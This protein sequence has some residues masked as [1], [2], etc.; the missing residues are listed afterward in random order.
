[1][2][3]LN[4]LR[5]FLAAARCGSFTRAARDLCITQPAVSGHIAQLEAA[6]GAEL[7]NRTGREVVLTDAGR[8]VQKAARDIMDRLESMQSELADLEALKGGTIKIGASKIIGV[9]LLPKIITAF[10]EKFPEIELQVA[11]HNAH[12]IA[13]SVLDNAF[14]I[15]IVA[16]GDQF[17]SKS[18]GSTTI[19]YDD[20]TIIASPEYVRR[21]FGRTELSVEQAGRESFILPGKATASAQNLKAQLAEL[22][23]RLRSTIEIDEAGA[24]KRAVED[25]A[26]LAVISRSVVERELADGRLAELH[27]A[28]WSPRQRILMLWRCD[29]RFSKNTEAFMRFLKSCLAETMSS[30][31]P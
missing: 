7:F 11:I 15:A 6:I 30:D 25:D 10:R 21:R 13:Q 27:I 17:T 24:I 29:R 22:G 12:T 26:G 1:M 23:I 28:G 18:L 31:A 3:V 20:L 4:H 19:G 16:E 9:Y 14:D 2:I 8:V 5:T